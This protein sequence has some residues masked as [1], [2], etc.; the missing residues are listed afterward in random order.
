M[1]DRGGNGERIGNDGCFRCRT[2]CSVTGTRCATG[3]CPWNAFQERMHRLR[4]E[5][6]QT[7]LEGSRCP[8]AKTPA[9][10]LYST[11]NQP[12]MGAYAF[13]T[14]H[15]LR[16]VTV[17]DSTIPD[18]FCYAQLA[19]LGRFTAR[20]VLPSGQPHSRVL[21]LSITPFSASC[22]LV[23]QLLLSR[24]AHWLV[25][26]SIASLPSRRALWLVLNPR[27]TPALG[28]D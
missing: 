3:L 15:P 5:V 21:C 1:I 11:E 19:F 2:D 20:S 10:C 23:L 22:F 12:L 18:G 24:R 28:A 14:S 8:C 25:L 7:L 16:V 9:T 27:Q 13:K 6:K 4:R 26:N 17:I